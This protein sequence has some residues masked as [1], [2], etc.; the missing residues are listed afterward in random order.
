MLRT[1]QHELLIPNFQADV[2]ELGFEAKM[3]DAAFELEDFEVDVGQHG[4]EEMR[5]LYHQSFGGRFANL[6]VLFERLMTIVTRLR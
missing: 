4:G 3:T 6:C 2:V 1:E 5:R